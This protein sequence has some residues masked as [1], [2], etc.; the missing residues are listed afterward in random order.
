MKEPIFEQIKL[1]KNNSY[2]EYLV[3]KDKEL[4]LN[5]L[6]T[7]GFYFAEVKLEK[8]QNPNNTVSLIYN[9]DLGKKAKIRKIKFIGDKKYKNRKLFRIIAS[10]ENKFWKFISNDILLNES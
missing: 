3:K 7:N 10:E 1:K 5:I 9:I 2:N 8:I 6:K 4:I